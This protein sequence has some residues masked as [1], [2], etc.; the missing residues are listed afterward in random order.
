MSYKVL[1]FGSSDIGL[2]R[3]NNEDAWNSLPQE[4]FFV[5]ADGMGGHKAG[6]VA[7]AETV[8]VLSQLIQKAWHNSE[9]LTLEESEGYLRHAIEVVNRIIYQ[10]SKSDDEFRGMGTT[11]CTVFFHDD[12]IIYAHVGDSRIYC[13]HAGKLDLLT[14]DDSLMREMMDLGQ[15]NEK[16]ISEALYKNVLTKAVGTELHIDP[17]VHTIDVCQNDIYLMCTDGLSDL[18]SFEE[19][20]EI[21]NLSTSLED[22]GNSLVKR[23]KENGGYDNITLILMQIKEN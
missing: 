21:L 11:L 1:S 20:E 2:V 10:L 23:A 3:Q 14:N 8:S 17:S 12:G 4:R 13:F 18:V 19:I 7:S 6:E 5:L 22:A 16:Q 9:K 15:L